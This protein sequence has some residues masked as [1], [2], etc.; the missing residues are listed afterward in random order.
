[1]PRPLSLYHVSYLSLAVAAWIYYEVQN[2]SPNSVVHLTLTQT[3]A[4]D[5]D[6]YVQVRYTYH[7]SA[8]MMCD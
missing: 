2:V 4:G 5:A 7:E 8:C 3:T 1:L 6:L